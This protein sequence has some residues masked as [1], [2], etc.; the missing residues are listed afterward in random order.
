MDSK[1]VPYCRSSQIKASSLYRNFKFISYTIKPTIIYKGLQKTTSLVKLETTIS[2][3]Y[4]C[5]TNT[6][7]IAISVYHWCTDTIVSQILYKQDGHFS[8]WSLEQRCHK[9]GRQLVNAKHSSTVV[10]ATQPSGMTG[11]YPCL[12]FG[13]SP[14][15]QIERAQKTP[16]HF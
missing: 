11:S 13:K 2:K 5:F 12:T 9:L 4:H 7:K 8:S 3:L 16:C 10:T 14:Q 1:V 6:N 15:S